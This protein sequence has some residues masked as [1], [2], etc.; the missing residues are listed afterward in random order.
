[1]KFLSVKY[2]FSVL[3]FWIISIKMWL[4]EP[5]HHFS[6]KK[7]HLL[8]EILNQFF[9]GQRWSQRM[10]LTHFLGVKI[11]AKQLHLTGQ[12]VVPLH[13]TCRLPVCLNNTCEYIH[14]YI[15]VRVTHGTSG[16]RNKIKNE[17]LSAD[18]THILRA[19]SARGE[20]IGDLTAHLY[21]IG[22]AFWHR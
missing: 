20:E 1:M 8:Q 10:K 17:T 14:T 5:K 15:R 22:G 3:C 21:I 18:I 12:C 7:Y 9:R 2:P 6:D 19:N 11:S 16:E 13:V 4:R